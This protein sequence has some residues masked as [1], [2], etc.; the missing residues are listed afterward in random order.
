MN[1]MMIVY[2]I[3]VYNNYLILVLLVIIIILFRFYF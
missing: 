1:L 2:L 3:E